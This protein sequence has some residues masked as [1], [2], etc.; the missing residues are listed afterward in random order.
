MAQF[1]NYK[2]HA[3]N[4]VH[5]YK[6][7]S[8][9]CVNLIMLL[10]CILIINITSAQSSVIIANDKNADAGTTLTIPGKEYDRSA[11]HNLFWGKHYR[12]EWTTPVRVKIFYLDTAKGGL[13]P[14]QE[15]GSRQ[16]MGLRLEDKEA[17][18]YV[19]RSIDK[20][21]GN[22]LPD[23][24]HGTFISHI[25]KDQ[26]SI[27]YPF[28]AI[29]IT[30]MLDAAG[31]YHTNP[32]IVFVPSQK[33]LGKYNKKYGSQLYLFEERPDDNSEDA[34]YFGNAKKIIGSEKL[35]EHLYE[36]NDYSVDQKAFAKARLFDMVI[37]DWSRH[38]DQWRWAAIKD[39]DKTI[40]KP[41]PRD[42]DQA[43]TR[44]DG[45]YS[46][47]ATNT[48]ARFLESFDNKINNVADFN[49][50]GRNLDRQFT[51]QLTKQQW[52]NIA[53]ELQQALTDSVIEYSMHQLPPE[54]FAING[55]KITANLK[56]RRDHLQDYAKQYYKYLAKRVYVPGSDKKELFE[57]NR[58]N[59]NETEISVYKIKKNNEKE[60]L[61]SRTFDRRESAE[62]FFIRL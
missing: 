33:A 6:R 2:V 62:I 55:E 48:V 51:N 58:M 54:M 47:I 23:I 25:A 13:I 56:A 42:R 3:M 61:F 15:A 32:E 29:T 27:G 38:A 12:K 60:L 16:S 53:A 35:Y 10:G 1:Y 19:L 14:V 17:K 52:I 34:S 30:P 4:F 44:F 49:K 59:P 26:A 43:Y 20:D 28:A 45:V 40:Y 50:P 36:D 7:M 8:V 11:Y 22:G 41:I 21:F 18:Q 24:Y 46:F 5:Y 39:E 31:I 9:F 37:G 57:I